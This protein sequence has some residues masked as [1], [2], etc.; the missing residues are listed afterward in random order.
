MLCASGSQSASQAIWI[1]DR[2]Y[3]HFFYYY[4]YYY[5]YYYRYYR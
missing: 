1:H 5:Y 3:L 4:Y 2:L